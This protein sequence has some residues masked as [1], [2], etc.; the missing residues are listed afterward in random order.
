M[1]VDAV[2]LQPA[3]SAS[4]HVRLVSVVMT[5]FKKDLQLHSEAQVGESGKGFFV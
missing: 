1:L 4:G 2:C 3:G 5:Y